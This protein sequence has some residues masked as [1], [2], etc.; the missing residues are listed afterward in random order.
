MLNISD[1]LNTIIKVH[2]DKYRNGVSIS[3][4]TN[5]KSFEVLIK[6][7]GSM[8]GHA[9]YNSKYT[10]DIDFPLRRLHK[11]SVK[12]NRSHIFQEMIKLV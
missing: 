3:I 8:A 6:A 12:I 9:A 2:N 11:L 4:D 7:Q 10:I 5:I 1:I